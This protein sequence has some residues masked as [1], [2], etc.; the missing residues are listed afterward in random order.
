MSDLTSNQVRVLQSLAYDLIHSEGDGVIGY[1]KQGE[2]L[3]QM[4]ELTNHMQPEVAV[5]VQQNL[6]DTQAG[7][8]KSGKSRFPKEALRSNMRA[9]YR[10]IVKKAEFG[11]DDV[12][13]HQDY[14]DTE[15]KEMPMSLRTIRNYSALRSLATVFDRENKAKLFAFLHN[16][17]WKVVS[18][19][20]PHI[21]EFNYEQLIDSFKDKS[22]DEI[23]S[24][25]LEMSGEVDR[26][27]KSFV[28]PAGVYDEY[29]QT[30]VPRIAEIIERVS[31][32]SRLVSWAVQ[33]DE[34]ND[35]SRTEV[36]AVLI[37]L[38]GALSED[39][40]LAA[41]RDAYGE[42]REEDYEEWMDE[43]VA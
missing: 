13:Y 12:I 21:R 14:V 43:K 10:A 25:G 41:V 9:T 42:L 17:P 34:N 1:L 8:T 30:T 36:L 20:A 24:W 38:T 19:V 7:L 28:M 22:D 35:A 39:V 18:K 31:P 32:S 26:E 11:Y 3:T 5:R 6:Y 15:G 23:V 4:A 33:D 16:Y 27:V 40:L 2:I 29:V 37:H